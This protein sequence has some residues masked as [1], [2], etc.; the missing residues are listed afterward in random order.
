MFRPTLTC[1]GHGPVTC[2][3]VADGM[4]GTTSMVMPM[5]VKEFNKA[6]AA[7]KAGALVQHAF[8]LLNAVQREFLLTGMEPSQQ[9]VV[10]AAP[11]D[12]DYYA[13]EDDAELR[14]YWQHHKNMG[15]SV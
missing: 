6:H 4:M 15:G 2:T 11:T 10:F 14:A 12:A 9:D 7:W 1:T 3:V 5:S 8:P 13:D